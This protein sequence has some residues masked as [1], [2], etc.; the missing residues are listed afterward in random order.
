MP[1]H[2]LPSKCAFRL[3][4]GG[5]VSLL[6]LPAIASAQNPPLADVARKEAERR[7]AL[8]ESTKVITDKDLP[9]SAR[10]GARPA[11]P[12][13]DATVPAAAGANQKPAAAG[14]AAGPAAQQAADDKG[15]S[16]WR[17]RINN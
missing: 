6:L 5:L 12:A 14:S 9:E 3:F 11:A 7:K 8:K 15:E 13:G 2:I 10:K 17:G 16:Y 4:V 1:D